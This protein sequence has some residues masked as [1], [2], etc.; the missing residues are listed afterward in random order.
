MGSYFGF[1]ERKL[2]TKQNQ[3]KTKKY[4]NS[5]PYSEQTECVI[6]YLLS[7]GVSGKFVLMYVVYVI[8][9]NCE[10]N[11]LWT[12][13]LRAGLNRWVCLTQFMHVPKE[14]DIV[15]SIWVFA[16][17]SS[18]SIINET[19]W[20]ASAFFSPYPFFTDGPSCINL[21]FVVDGKLRIVGRN[22]N[23]IDNRERARLNKIKFQPIY[24]E[25]EK[26]Y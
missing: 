7:P 18:V 15:I 11:N 26:D 12:A 1:I 2:Y 13:Y 25:W 14:H 3:N 17:L 21:F 4:K 9:K 5:L 16:N 24:L 23:H 22:Q 20:F 19:F 6:N 10:N 8:V